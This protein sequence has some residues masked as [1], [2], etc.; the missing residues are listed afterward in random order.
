MK[1]YIVIG[2]KIR[3]K[4]DGDRHY[5]DAHRLC[6]LYRINPQ[7][8]YLEEANNYRKTKHTYPLHLIKLRPRYDGNYNLQEAK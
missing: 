2:G 5:I 1:K 7:E 8:C 4:T 6:E 3:S